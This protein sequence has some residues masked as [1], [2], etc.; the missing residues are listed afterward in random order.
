MESNHNNNPLQ[1]A[2]LKASQVGN[3]SL[4]REL[5]LAGANPTTVES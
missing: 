5:I 4:M 2:L 1:F 3:I